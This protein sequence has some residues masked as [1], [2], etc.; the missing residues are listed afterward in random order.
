MHYENCHG[1]S[2]E[3]ANYDAGFAMGLTTYPELPLEPPEG[4]N[5]EEICKTAEEIWADYLDRKYP[6][7]DCPQNEVVPSEI[8]SE[9]DF[10]L[11]QTSEA[12]DSSN[13]DGNKE[14]DPVSPVKL[15]RENFIE[16]LKDLTSL[17]P[18]NVGKTGEDL[19]KMDCP[20]VE[21]P[22]TEDSSNEEIMDLT[23]WNNE[24]S[25]NMELKMG[26]EIMP[27]DGFSK[28]DVSSF[29]KEIN[30]EISSNVESSVPPVGVLDVLNAD[31]NDITVVLPLNRVGSPRSIPQQIRADFVHEEQAKIDENDRKMFKLTNKMKIDIKNEI[32]KIKI[33]KIFRKYRKK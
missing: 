9:V 6:K 26:E 7:I 31:E 30:E 13:L 29:D 21:M 3:E 25:S 28:L 4:G 1:L 20:L 33:F 15:G 8:E 18:S 32:K 10:L 24:T 22:E 5:L 16:E 2:T 23:P 19:I 12:E 11:P 17:M 27:S 14:G